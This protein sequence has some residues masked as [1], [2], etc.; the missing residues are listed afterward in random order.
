MKLADIC[1][2]ISFV[3]AAGG[4]ASTVF[5][6]SDLQK[7]TVDRTIR[8]EE[9]F[10][11]EIQYGGINNVVARVTILSGTYRAE[12][13]D[14][15]GVYFRGPAQCFRTVNLNST[16]QGALND[17]GIYLPNANE[18]AP[19]VYVYR[20]DASQQQADTTGTVNSL[21][22]QAT[23]KGA[24][25]VSSAAGAALGGA[26]VDAIIASDRDKP[27]FVAKTVQ[28][29]LDADFRAKLKAE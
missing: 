6:P 20:R 2:I 10:S 22:A 28:S 4:C 13:E 14:A 25:V 3:A 27:R 23:P 12:H 17:C 1:L 5:D 19:R 9:D 26:I 21:A 11:F 7:P 16:L 29:H 24:A 15:G 8:L 18:L